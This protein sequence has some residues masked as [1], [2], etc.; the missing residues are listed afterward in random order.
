VASPTHE[1]SIVLDCAD[2]DTLAIFWAEALSYEVKGT[3][4]QY[5]LVAPKPGMPGVRLLLQGVAEPKTVK[6]RVHLDLHTND[7]AEEVARLVA[8]GARLLEEEPRAM[9]RTRW[10]VLAD[11]EGNEFCVVSPL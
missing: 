6:N 1:V 8:L 4:E 3:M 9:G 2:P 5:A 10:H 7:L 11:P